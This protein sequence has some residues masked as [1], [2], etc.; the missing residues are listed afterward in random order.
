[1]PFP[2]FKVVIICKTTLKSFRCIH[3]RSRWK[4]VSSKYFPS[5]S[6]KTS[7]EATQWVASNEYAQHIFSWRNKQN[8][9]SFGLKK[10][11]YQ[12]LWSIQQNAYPQYVCC[13]Q[14]LPFIH[15]AFALFFFWSCKLF[16]PYCSICRSQSLSG[17]SWIHFQPS[18]H[19]RLNHQFNTDSMSWIN[20]ESTLFQCCVNAGKRS[21]PVK[22]VFVPLQKG[23]Y[24]KR[25]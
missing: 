4:R 6:K 16:L 19:I 11:S 18:R 9:N 14:P 8:I 17:E 20:V 25:T 5:F 3:H 7:L 13:D 12:E 1:M 22:I 10:A 23:V 15:S 24:S 2:V 21:I